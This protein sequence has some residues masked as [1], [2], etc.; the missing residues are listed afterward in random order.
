MLAELE[1]R[2]LAIAATGLAIGLAGAHAWPLLVLWILFAAW[3]AMPLLRESEPRSISRPSPIAPLIAACA[4]LMGLA[5][6]P[7]V[8]HSGIVSPEFVTTTATITSMPREHPTGNS[9]TLDFGSMKVLASIPANLSLGM[10]DRLRIEGVIQPLQEGMDEWALPENIVGTMQLHSNKIQVIGKGPYLYRIAQGWRAQLLLLTERSLPSD[11]AALIDALCFGATGGLDM[12][13]QDALKR[14]GIIHIV[15]ASGLHVFILVALVQAVLGLL[16][17]PRGVSL[18]LIAVLLLLYAMAAGLHPGTIR[19]AIMALAGSVAY[20]FRKEADL[21]SSLALAAILVLLWQPASIYEPGFHLTFVVVL[22][23]GLYSQTRVS[24]TS[25][26]R[27]GLLPMLK[28]GVVATVASAPIAAYAFGRVSILGLF[29]NAVVIVAVAPIIALA[30]L[31]MIVQ[32]IWNGAAVT[33]MHIAGT[34]A[35]GIGWFLDS[36]GT[37]P[38]ASID[39]PAFSPYWLI[40]FYGVPLIYWRKRVREP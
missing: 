32:P 30:M 28:S 16:P 21:I 26:A 38:W 22:A 10:G 2:P 39:V 25:D 35:N 5:L 6:A 9:C 17:I 13:R 11:Q 4:G 34:L 7:N 36:L 23:L 3:M 19:A 14:T 8:P 12:A 24:A 15:A 33:L 40:L 18:G 20:L 1:H 31:A 29:A 27:S 37:H